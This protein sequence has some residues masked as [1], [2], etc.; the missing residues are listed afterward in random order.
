MSVIDQGKEKLD[1]AAEYEGLERRSK[2]RVSEPFPARVRGVDGDGH[3]FKVIV[4]L[5]NLS[6]G[7]VYLR[8]SQMVPIGTRLLLLIG[9]AP[10][11]DQWLKGPLVSAQ[12]VVVRE[13]SLHGGDRGVAVMFTHYRMR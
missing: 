12:G 6:A 4:E 7:G 13:D 9:L 1:S 5:D 8:I 2:P 10:S 11:S 3:K